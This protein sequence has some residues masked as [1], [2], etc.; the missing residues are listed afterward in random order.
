MTGIDISPRAIELARTNFAQRGSPG[1]FAV[2]D[3]EALEFPDR[4]F[5]VVY[6]HTVL[7]FTPHPERMVG[8]IHR[9]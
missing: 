9:V 7:H 8:E 5:D 6:C 2:M 3:G 4:S 1:G